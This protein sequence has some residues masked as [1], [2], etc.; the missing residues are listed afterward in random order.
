MPLTQ[1]LQQRPVRPEFQR[2]PDLLR[3]SAS[4]LHGMTR[5]LELALEVTQSDFALLAVRNGKDIDVVASAG[6]EAAPREGRHEV[7]VRLNEVLQEHYI[8]MRGEPG[9]NDAIRRAVPAPYG[10][11]F[12]VSCPVP[13]RYHNNGRLTLTCAG[14]GVFPLSSFRRLGVLRNLCH[15][16]GDEIGIAIRPSPNAFRETSKPYLAGVPASVRPCDLPARSES[17]DVTTRFLLDTV[18]RRRRLHTR[19]DVAYHSVAGWRSA[20]K[21]YQIDALRAIKCDPPSSFLIEVADWIA[22]AARHLSHADTARAVVPVPG[23]HSGEN[24]VSIRIGSIVASML[25]LEFVD[26]FETLSV[27]GRS[28]HPKSNLNRSRMRL[29][30]KVPGPV[31]LVD[32]VATS[33]SHIGEAAVALRQNGT[34]TMPIVWIGPN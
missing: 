33:G 9:W 32:D 5:I 26:A 25:G 27:E 4:L 11:D 24:A 16:V 12:V 10:I 8:S 2:L 13:F 17:T 7:S 23:G 21:R 28:S 18:V 1:L 14:R 29:K 6:N 22:D 34:V 3:G 30:T 19:G 31:L 20:L 15:I